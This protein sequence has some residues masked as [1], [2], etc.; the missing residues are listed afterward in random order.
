MDAT[1]RLNLRPE[2]YFNMRVE[3]NISTAAS[4][5]VFLN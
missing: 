1:L 2:N 3:G 5:I 4:I